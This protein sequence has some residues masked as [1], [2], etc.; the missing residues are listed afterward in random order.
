MLL[1]TT[2]GHSLQWGTD[3]LRIAAG[4]R[5]RVTTACATD[6][7][8]RHGLGWASTRPPAT[9]TGGAPGTL[10]EPTQLHLGRNG[11]VPWGCFREEEGVQAT[12]S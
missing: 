12:S 8:K 6:S 11:V 3:L 7:R 2:R 1:I 4:Q 5:L 9:L 10:S